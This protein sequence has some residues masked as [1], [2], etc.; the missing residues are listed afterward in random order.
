MRVHK[1][2]P[3][4]DV[5][6]AAEAAEVLSGQCEL[7]VFERLVDLAP[8]AAGQGLV[9]WQAVFSVRDDAQDD[10]QI[11]MTLDFD[12]QLPMTCQRCL[13]DVD[14]PVQAQRRF[15]FVQTEALAEAQD[16]VCE[17]DVLV[18]SRTF[19][20]AELLEDEILM[21]IPLLPRHEVCP[22]ALKLSASDADFVDA[23]DKPNPFAA[24]GAIKSRKTH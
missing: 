10:A 1:I 23:P 17:E 8:G 9:R 18:L 19:N 14:V 20:L 16:D 6:R 15:R 24:L 11:W 7:A 3:T 12:L 22:V 13:G 21:A 5:K 4:L 2:P